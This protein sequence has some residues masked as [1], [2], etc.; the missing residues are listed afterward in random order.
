M[1][2][3]LLHGR[4]LISKFLCVHCTCLDGKGLGMVPGMLEICRHSGF[5]NAL[6]RDECK[7]KVSFLPS[8]QAFATGVSCGH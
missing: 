5:L 6:R 8:I 4:W 7:C 3:G 1:N 2:A